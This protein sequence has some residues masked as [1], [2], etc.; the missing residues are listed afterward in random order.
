MKLD[1]DMLKSR[2]AQKR[3]PDEVLRLKKRIYDK[4]NQ[5]FIASGKN[6]KNL[7]DKVDLDQSNQIELDEFKNMFRSMKV[8]ASDF[9]LENIFFSIDFDLS[10]KITYP[11]FIADFD[12]Y[13]KNDIHSLIMQE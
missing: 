6:L 4:M 7:F 11:E 13:I 10:G 9:E 1:D 12:N 5:A 3:I 2:K 8:E